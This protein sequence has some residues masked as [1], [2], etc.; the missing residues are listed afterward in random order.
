MVTPSSE[1]TEP[2]IVPFPSYSNSHFVTNLLTKQPQ[3]QMQSKTDFTSPIKINERAVNSLARSSS[4]ILR[5]LP[6]LNPER[7]AKE[8]KNSNQNGSRMSSFGSSSLSKMQLLS[9]D[10]EVYEKQRRG[11]ELDIISNVPREYRDSIKVFPKIRF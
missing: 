7:S 5:P 8:E 11:R 4:E 2:F 10:V 9:N 6:Q 3:Q 1:N